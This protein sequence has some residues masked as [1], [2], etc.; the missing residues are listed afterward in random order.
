MYNILNEW[1]NRISYQGKAQHSKNSIF[2]YKLEFYLQPA[3]N[4]L[5]HKKEQNIHFQ[6][7][8]EYENLIENRY[9]DEKLQCNTKAMVQNTLLPRIQKNTFLTVINSSNQYLRNDTQV[10]HTA[11]STSETSLITVSGTHATVWIQTQM[12]ASHLPLSA[13]TFS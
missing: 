11:C 10:P 5:T 12:P 6:G 9:R 4:S 2:N 3:W 13:S 1:L 7:C 8:L